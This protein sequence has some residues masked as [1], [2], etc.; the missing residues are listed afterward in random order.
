MT[1]A[2]PAV[3]LPGAGAGRDITGHLP[4][5]GLLLIMAGPATPPPGPGSQPA[6]PRGR[7]GRPAVWLR[8]AA[9]GLCARAAPAAAVSFAAR[10]RLVQAPPHPPVVAALE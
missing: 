7:G 1:V 2:I 8:H 5:S 10:Y 4:A 3:T 9:A 6:P